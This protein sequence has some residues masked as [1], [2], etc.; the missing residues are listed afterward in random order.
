MNCN[1]NDYWVS[2]TGGKLGYYG[3]DKTS[4][5]IVTGVT[6]NDASSQSILPG[7]VNPG[8]TTANS[9]IPSAALPAA[10]GTGITSDYGGSTRSLTSPEMGAWEQGNTITWNSHS[11][12]SWS[13]AA[14]WNPQVVPTASHNI[15]VPDG[16]EDLEINQAVSSPAMCNN[17]TIQSG[18]KVIILPGKALTVNGTLTNS[19]GSSRL[20][21]ESDETG[22]GSLIQSSSSVGATIE[23]YITGSAILTENRYHFVSIPVYYASPTSNLFLGSYL[24]KMDATQIDPDNSN[25][26]GKWVNLGTSTTNPL[27]CT[28]G[29]MIYYPAPSTTYTFTGTLNTG[30]F[31]PTV[32]YGGT[33][34]FNLVPNPYPSAI[35]WGSSSGWVK[36]NIGA[37]AWIWSKLA[38]NYVTLSGPSYVPAGQAFLVMASGTPVLTMNNNACVHDATAFYKSAEANTLKI[39][40]QSNN[41]YD[42]TFVSFN[43][44]AGKEFDP[45]YDGFKLWGL[46][47]APQLWTEKGESRLSINQLPPPSGA[48]IVPLDFKTSYAGQVTLNVSGIENFDPSLA[49]RLQ[50]HV[51]GSWTDLRQKSTY[52][53]THDTSNT[54]KRFNL[55]F[56]YPSGINTNSNSNGKAFISNGRIYLDVPSMQGHLA[57]ITVY[58][59]LGQVIRSQEKTMDGIVSIEAELARGVYIVRATTAD[60]NFST[61][62]INK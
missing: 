36:S 35:N 52:A 13:I 22:T 19:G 39:S 11:S 28:S 1:Y 51:N 50:D 60:Q 31:S 12:K 4:L 62:V 2:G 55:V 58:D 20:V 5:P 29:Y 3:G 59:M 30:S 56:G 45:Q 38:G 18:A 46:E 40:A 21:I 16:T 8:G 42:E 9:Y 43:P 61:K 53:F 17:M 25:Y 26:Y 7:F 34:T 44:A 23:R 6:G 37:T 49:I 48:L 14:N 57:G 41:Y 15:L 33:Y 10:T 47:D 32:S 27:L 24:Y 54:E